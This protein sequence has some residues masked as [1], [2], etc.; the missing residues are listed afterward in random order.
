MGF[1]DKIIKND[2]QQL[3]QEQFEYNNKSGKLTAHTPCKYTH[4]YG[5]ISFLTKN[6]WISPLGKQCTGQ[7]PRGT[8]GAVGEALSKIY[9]YQ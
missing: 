7:T 2:I 6:P 5:I 8:S 1:N 9:P 4:H 3:K